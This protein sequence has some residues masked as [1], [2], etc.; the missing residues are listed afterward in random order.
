MVR[1]AGAFDCYFRA[2]ITTFFIFLP[3]FHITFF[4]V[5]KYIFS[6]ATCFLWFV[7]KSTSDLY[8]SFECR[9]IEWKVNT[10]YW[11]SPQCKLVRRQSNQFS[12]DKKHFHFILTMRLSEGLFIGRFNILFGLQ[13]QQ[14]R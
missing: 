1:N 4:Y 3:F 9:K 6:F 12:I 8:E 11:H 5:Y 2:G 10:F 7:I 14:L 13:K